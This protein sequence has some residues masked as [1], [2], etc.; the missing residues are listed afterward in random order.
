MKKLLVAGIAA[1][2]FCGA[3]AIAA[4]PAAPMFNWSGFYIGVNGGGMDFTT[5]GALVVAPTSSWRTDSHSTGFAGLHGGFQGQWGNLVVGVEGAWDAAFGSSFGSRDGALGGA[6]CNATPGFAC[7]ARINDILQVGPRIGFAM[8][9][10]MVYGTAGYARAEVES[11]F[12]VTPTGNPLGLQPSTHHDG[13]YY[14]GGLEIL[15]TN[16]FIIGVEY[17]HYDFKSAVQFDTGGGSVNLKANADAVLLRL[18]I[19]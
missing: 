1:A 11:R 16:N 18:T 5:N 3:P 15:V 7:Q 14:G 10:W 17:K 6:P 4:P 9:Q 12:F 19:K 2:A 8:N 13:W